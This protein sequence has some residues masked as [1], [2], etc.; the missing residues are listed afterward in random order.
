MRVIHVLRKPLSEGN[1]AANV[2]KEGCG[3]LNIDAGRITTSPQDAEAMG[4]CNSPG[5]GRFDVEPP[6]IG[7][8]VRS[9]PEPVMD[10]T[11][12]RWPANLILEHLPGCRCVGKKQVKNQGGV[13][14]TEVI[15]PHVVVVGPSKKRTGFSHYFDPDSG[16][17][18]IDAWDCE[19]GCPVANLDGQSGERRST[20]TGCESQ[21]HSEARPVSKFRPNQGTYMPQGPLY[22]DNGGASR[23]FKQIKSECPIPDAPA[24]CKAERENDR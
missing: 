7:T 13:P 6:P 16:M 21:K 14:K 12:G 18:T 11:K 23:F 17:E 2:L 20:W 5:S 15:Q 8:F 24:S 22:G 4:R 9:N 3:G 19:P 1:V 10:T